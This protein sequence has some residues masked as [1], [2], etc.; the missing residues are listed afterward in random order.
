L[1]SFLLTL[2]S[3]TAF[4]YVPGLRTTLPAVLGSVVIDLTADSRDASIFHATGSLLLTV[5]AFGTAS[6]GT[7]GVP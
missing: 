1:E 3:L 6:A 5:A 4:L 7:G 2:Y